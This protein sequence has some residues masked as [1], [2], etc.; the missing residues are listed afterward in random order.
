M[1]SGAGDE[2]LPRLPFLDLS[3]SPEP[4]FLRSFHPL[5]PP[6]TL[7]DRRFPALLRPSEFRGFQPLGIQETRIK[8][9]IENIRKYTGLMTVVFVLLFIGLIYM[10]NEGGGNRGYGSGEI[11]VTAHGTSYPEQAYRRLGENPVRLLQELTRTGRQAQFTLLGYLYEMANSAQAPP[12]GSNF[13]ARSYLVNRISLQQ[14]ADEFG[15][16]AS[17]AEIEQFMRENL[18]VTPTGDFDETAYQNFIDKR[19]PRLGMGNKELYETLGDV[20]VYQKLSELL[21]SGLSPSRAALRDSVENNLQQI[22]YQLVEFKASLFEGKEE[23]TEEEIREYWDIHKG[24]YLSDPLRKVSYIIAEPDFDAI[25]KEDT[26]EEQAAEGEETEEK[27]EDTPDI[28]PEGR[29]AAIA[30]AGDKL[31]IL[32]LKMQDADGQGFSELATKAGFTVQESELV[33]ETN[34][35]V[36]L[37]GVIAGKGPGSRAIFQQTYPGNTPMDTISDLLKIGNNWVIFRVDKVVDA[38]EQT[39]EEAKAQAKI[40][41]VKERAHTAMEEKANEAHETLVAELAKGTSFADATKAL[42]LTPVSFAQVG[43]TKPALGEPTPRE[44]FNLVKVVTPGELSEVLTQKNENRSI[45]RSL[46]AFV[47]KRELVDDDQ[48]KNTLEQGYN[49]QEDI[50]KRIAFSNWLSQ[51]YAAANVTNS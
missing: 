3:K 45:F 13:D 42:E 38:K 44:V 1:D 23:P 6:S 20:L 33:S 34:L 4:S 46:F 25:A 47:E 31:D 48:L 18:F 19:L 36:P 29:E 41:L 26:T 9:M 30:A 16:H 24:K 22:D 10:G 51:K 12:V 37:R 14:G 32:W 35:P 27:P 2:S 17:D 11:V 40:D 15:L 21:G 28:T 43:Q 8:L 39:Y 49:R 50:T 5:K 7:D